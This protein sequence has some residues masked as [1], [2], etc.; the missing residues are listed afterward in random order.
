MN[1]NTND[2]I[3]IWEYQLLNRVDRKPKQDISVTH[4]NTE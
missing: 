3:Q 4:H 2:E 1:T